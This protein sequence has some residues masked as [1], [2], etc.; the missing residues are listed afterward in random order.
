MNLTFFGSGAF[1]VPTLEALAREH[2]IVGVVTQ[3]DRPAGRGGEITP[4][5][6]AEFAARTLVGV[7]VLKPENVNEASMVAQIQAWGA[8]AA[9]VIAFGQKL[10]PAVL[11]G[12]VRA[13]N[14]HASLLPRWRGAAP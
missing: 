12:E 7:S 11:P 2:R 1:G 14:L 3:P 9:V 13:I 6:V 4:T 10:S 5:P 8:H